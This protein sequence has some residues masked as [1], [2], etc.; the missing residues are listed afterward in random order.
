[1]RAWSIDP[2]L[3]PAQAESKKREDRICITDGAVRNPAGKERETGGVKPAAYESDPRRLP[4]A[5]FKRLRHQIEER[6]ERPTRQGEGRTSG[7]AQSEAA[8]LTD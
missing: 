1:M 6:E 2:S 3:E 5:A 7:A 8:S 4:I